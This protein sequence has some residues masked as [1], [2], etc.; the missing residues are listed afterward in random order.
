MVPEFDTA[1]FTLTNNQ[2]SDVVTTQYGYHIIQQLG[3]TP[4][5]QV[6]YATVADN[7]KDSLAQQKMATIAPAYL[8]KITKAAD[9]EILDAELKA[10]VE[11]AAVDA[12]ANTPTTTPA[13]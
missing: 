2:I 10:A 8:D 3:K 7:I 13:N 11:K 1:A 9:V 12:Q 4:A 5:K 6:D